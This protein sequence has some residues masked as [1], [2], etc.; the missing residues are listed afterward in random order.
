MT[1][2]ESVKHM[3]WWGWGVEGVA[4]HHA[5]K[6]NFAPFVLKAVGLDLSKQAG[7]PPEFGDL[8]VPRTKALAPV[9]KALAAVVGEEQVIVDDEARVVHTY[10]KSIRDLASQHS[11]SI[12][13]SRNLLVE[14]GIPLRG[15]GGSTRGRRRASSP[16]PAQ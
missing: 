9:R 1:D 13:L 5:D 8:K 10:G 7:S 15:R 14:S 11:L 12:G 16:R 3:K 6:P 2:V 4:F